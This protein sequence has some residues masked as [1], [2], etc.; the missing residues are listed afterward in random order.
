MDFAYFKI[1]RV[2]C[3]RCGT[4]LMHVNRSKQDS[5]ARVMWCRCGSV[6]LDPAPLGYRVRSTEGFGIV[7][8]TSKLWRE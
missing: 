3:L 1:C 2:R 6:G 8:D 4:V 5:S 7:E